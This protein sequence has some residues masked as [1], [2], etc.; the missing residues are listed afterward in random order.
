MEGNEG[1]DVQSV[2]GRVFGRL[3]HLNGWS[4]E[5]RVP[6]ASRRGTRVADLCTVLQDKHLHARTA[7]Q[8]N[9]GCARGS[10]TCVT[11]R[12]VSFDGDRR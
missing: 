6:F 9:L 2:A 8:L 5:P 7:A 1:D 12:L 10:P 4:M 11:Q 3:L